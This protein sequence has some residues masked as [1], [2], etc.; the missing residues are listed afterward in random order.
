M[1]VKILRTFP[2]GTYFPVVIQDLD[3]VNNQNNKLASEAKKDKSVKKNRL[4]VL[5]TS[6]NL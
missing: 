2:K 1:L 5:I 4:C 6:H 3:N